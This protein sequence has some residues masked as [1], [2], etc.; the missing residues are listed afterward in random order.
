MKE[1]IIH[2]FRNREI[3]LRVPSQCKQHT[4]NTTTLIKSDKL[5]FSASKSNPLKELPEKVAD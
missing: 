4:L 1:Q 2:R 5:L 3:F